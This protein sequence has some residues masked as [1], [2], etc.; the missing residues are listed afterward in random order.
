M[1][2]GKSCTKYKLLIYFR[3]EI[4]QLR[5]NFRKP[6]HHQ[7]ATQE[8]NEHLTIKWLFNTITELKTEVSEIQ[9]TLNTTAI[10]QNHEGVDTELSLLKTDVS[11]LNNEL[12]IAKNRNIKYE[13]QLLEIREELMSLKDQSKTTAVICGKT[14]NQVIYFITIIIF[15]DISTFLT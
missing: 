9:T 3:L 4:E 6:A 5:G 11:N 8:K 14:K 13:G 2:A 12:K 10:L 1:N 7:H 15:I